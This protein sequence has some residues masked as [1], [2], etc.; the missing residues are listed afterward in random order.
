MNKNF[1]NQAQIS[2]RIFFAHNGTEYAK[3]MSLTNDLNFLANFK[4]VGIPIFHRVCVLYFA[5][6]AKQSRK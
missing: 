1:N 2:L 6:R 4:S 3:E 5:T